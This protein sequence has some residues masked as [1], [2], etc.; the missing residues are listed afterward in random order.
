MA[1]LTRVGFGDG[2]GTTVEL[3]AVELADGVLSSLVV[4]HLDKAE[5]LATTGHAVRDDAGR[6]DLAVLAEQFV[7]L[8]LLGTEVQLCYKDVHSLK[9][10]LRIG[11]EL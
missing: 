7:E 11:I 4:G 1:V 6:C 10:K 9:D 5:A 3:K 2:D 8:P